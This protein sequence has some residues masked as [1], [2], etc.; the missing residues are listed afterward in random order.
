[1]KKIIRIVLFI[2]VFT[3]FL[4]LTKALFLDIYQDF[5][6]YYFAS[7]AAF[8]GINPYLSGGSYT[9][10][11]Y[12]PICLFFLF[13]FQLLPLV[14]ASKVW[15]GLSFIG[16]IFSLIIIL[17]IY[18]YSLFSSFSLVLF[19]LAFLFFPLK[20]TLGM[21]QINVFILLCLAFALYFFSRGKEA[22]VGIFFGLSLTIKYFPI[23]IILYLIF[24]KKWK[25]LQYL[26]LTVVFLFIMGYLFIDTSINNYFFLNTFP[27]LFQ[28]SGGYYYNQ[29]LSGFVSRTFAGSSMEFIIRILLSVLILFTTFFVMYKRKKI[30]KEIILFEI[31]IIITTNLLL[32]SFT[33]QH[34]FTW[35][36]IPLIFTAFQI[37]KKSEFFLLFIIFLLLTYNIKYP[38][39]VPILFQSHAFYGALLLWGFDLYLLHRA[40][41]KTILKK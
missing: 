32:S 35:L 30:N 27:S 14:I 9:G 20:F 22:L 28:S 18:K 34:H 29:A 31:G 37:H 3:S 11:I 26:F 12:P 40:N 5:N 19:T 6:Y 2:L 10:Y 1:M 7:Q 8:Q 33:W 17:R 4:Y 23:F 36:L 41:F 38:A 39:G 16:V 24:R 13:P 15:I 25:I 21:G